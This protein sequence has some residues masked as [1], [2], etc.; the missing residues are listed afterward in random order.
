MASDPSPIDI[1]ASVLLALAAFA[2]AGVV[3]WMRSPS[4]MDAMPGPVAPPRAML[5]ASMWLVMMAAM[6]LPAVTPVVLLFRTVQRGRAAQ[7]NLAIPTGVFVSGY[8]AVWGGDYAARSCHC[9]RHITPL[10]CGKLPS[11]SVTTD[12]QTS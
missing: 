7:G 11:S 6:M 12:R 10:G 9:P 8:L 3:L 5:F 4:M 1:Y 2:W